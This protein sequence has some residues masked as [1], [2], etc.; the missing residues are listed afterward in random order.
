MQRTPEASWFDSG[1]NL[2]RLTA[3]ALVSF[4]TDGFCIRERPGVQAA[5]LDICSS[6]NE[7]F[8]QDTAAG[9]ATLANLIC[10][11]NSVHQDTGINIGP[12]HLPQ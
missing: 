10:H 1:L 2:P 5:L 7:S 8:H 6:A 4:P 11:D 12:P 3:L 9:H